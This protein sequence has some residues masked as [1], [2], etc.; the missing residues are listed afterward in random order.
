MKSLAALLTSI[1]LV[2]S[3]QARE[4]APLADDPQLEARVMQVAGELRC[5]VCQ[6]ETIAASQADLAIDLRQQIRQKL[7]Q[8]ES[9]AQIL[10]FM[11]ARY[12]AFVRYRPAFDR[13]T[14]LLWLG[15]FALLA[16]GALAFGLRWRRGRSTPPLDEAQALQARRWLDGAPSP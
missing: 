8:G 1:V 5:L 16:G 10:D 14:A 4:A 2:A 9:P 3:L 15:P 7:S 11:V 12:G 13:V 6:N